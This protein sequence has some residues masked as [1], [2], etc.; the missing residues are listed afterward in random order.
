[1]DASNQL[2]YPEF[3]DQYDYVKKVVKSCKTEDQ[4][5]NAHRWAE[6]WSKRM[7]NLTPY[8]VYSWT[9]LYLDVTEI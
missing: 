2:S 1:M 9:D 6:D 8:F 5:K 4:I 3:L 7:K